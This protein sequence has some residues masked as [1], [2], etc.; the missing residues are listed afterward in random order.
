MKEAIVDY[1]EIDYLQGRIQAFQQDELVEARF[2]PSRLQQGIY[3]QRQADVQMIRVKIP[4]GS[5]SASQ[6]HAVQQVVERFS[7]QPFVH[8]TTRQ[9]IQ[10]YHVALKD[11][12]AALRMLA[13]VDLTSREACGNTVRNITACQL[14]G[15]CPHEHTDIRHYVDAVMRKFLRHPLTQHLPRKFKMSFSGCEADCAQ[16]LIHDI[17]VIATW[18]DGKPG[19]KLLAAGGLG[20]KQRQ[21]IVLESFIPK[22]NLSQHIEA[23]LWVHHRYSNRR[24]RARS[25]LKFLVDEFGQAGFMKRYKKALHRIL[26]REPDT[27]DAVEWQQ[28]QQRPADFYANHYAHYPIAIKKTR[29]YVVPVAIPLGD[30][31][32]QQIQGLVELMGEYDIERTVITQDQNLLLVGIVAEKQQVLAT[33]LK[34][35]DL[36]IMTSAGAVACPGTE[37]CRLGI[38]HSKGLAKNLAAYADNLRLHVAGCQN[39]CAQ[40]EV[41]DVGLYGEGKRLHGHF[42][43]YY[44]TWIGGHG[45]DGGQFARKGPA[46]PAQRATEYIERIQAAFKQSQQNDFYAWSRQQSIDQF[47][48]WAND[49]QPTTVDDARRLAVDVGADAAFKVEQ[50]GGGECAGIA[51]EFIDACCSEIRYEQGC[52]DAY[53]ALDNELQARQSLLQLLSLCCGVALLAFGKNKKLSDRTQWLDDFESLKNNA[54]YIESLRHWLSQWQGLNN[55]DVRDYST[56]L[57]DWLAQQLNPQA[58]EVLLTSDGVKLDTDNTVLDL[59]D[60]ACPMHYLKARKYL[61]GVAQGG[62]QTFLFISGD[63]VQQAMESLQKDGFQVSLLPAQGNKT[64]LQV[65]K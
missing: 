54:P 22:Q 57:D 19:F 61:K 17:G 47:N 48:D 39:G 38:T 7:S 59:S 35:L 50:F 13:D 41:A 64:P 43:P 53:L 33:A 10:I 8:L 55:S 1:K 12:P 37:S 15:T 23:V 18:R 25:R 26:V 21:A 36:R 58:L 44:Q 11:I 34:A 62:R 65:T 28:A 27:A 32:V 9:D 31:T 20:H 49:L 16:G 60:Y 42:I 3:G 45:Q 6:W 24:L 51:D 4:G 30:L 40:P 5:V 46:V 29:A 63:P 56:R 52:R 14:A 2:V